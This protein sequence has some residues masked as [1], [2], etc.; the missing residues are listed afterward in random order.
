[1]N[2]V[3]LWDIMLVIHIRK[4]QAMWSRAAKLTT[5]KL[6][7]RNLKKLEKLVKFDSF[8]VAKVPG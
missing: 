7:T 8:A 3:I 4:F 6:T 2:V 5:I 1:M